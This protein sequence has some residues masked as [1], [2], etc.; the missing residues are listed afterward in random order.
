[1]DNHH[2]R[3][4]VQC[5]RA[6]S[7]DEWAEKA[8][9][10]EALGYDAFVLPDHVGKQLAPFPAMLAAAQATERIK[11]GVLVLD[12]DFRHPLLLAHEAASLQVLT[13]GRLELG[14]GAGWNGRD[15]TALGIPF[16]VP[17]VRFTK[18]REAIEIVDR[19]LDGERFS[20]SGEHYRVTDVEPL[21]MPTRPPLLIAGGGPRM[22]RLAAERADIVGIFITSKKDGSGFEEAELKPEIFEEKCR[23]VWRIAH[24]AGRAPELNMLVQ[25]VEIT[26]DR[27]GVA[28]K[29][30]PE[31]GCDAE[32]LLRLPFE[33]IGTVDEIVDD[34]EERRRRY[35]ISYITVY[36]P[37]MDAMGLII[38][39]LHGR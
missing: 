9:H 38:E 39:R 5:A 23:R 19:Y 28:E 8:R 1:V 26:E 33:L 12:N 16:E 35:G 25:H 32:A 24:D 37:Y 27:A 18:L 13:G 14:I 15:Y 4:G 6:A 17:G 20:W 11:V 31:Y 21:A 10:A 36:E 30:A 2:F 7:A 29:R 34:L 22:L 3:F